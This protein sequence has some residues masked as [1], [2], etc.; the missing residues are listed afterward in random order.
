MPPPMMT[1]RACAGRVMTLSLTDVLNLVMVGVGRPS[2]SLPATKELVDGPPSR[3]MTKKRRGASRSRPQPLVLRIVD[4]LLRDRRRVALAENFDLDLRAWRA[5]V[6][7]HIG[8]RDAL[9]D[10][11]PVAAGADDADLRVAVEHDR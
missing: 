7:A 6:L 9:A 11:V 10:A 2:T 1:T 8:E 4:R 3:T 5:E